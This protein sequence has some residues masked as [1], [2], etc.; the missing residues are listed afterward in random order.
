MVH[1]NLDEGSGDGGHHGRA[2]G[3]SLE[4]SATVLMVSTNQNA[5]IL[6]EFVETHECTHQHGVE[7]SVDQRRLVV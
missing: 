1:H 6:D 2:A 4:N 7:S 3:R 5:R